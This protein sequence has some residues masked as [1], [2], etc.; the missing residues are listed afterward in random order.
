ME[1]FWNLRIWY[2]VYVNYMNNAG[3]RHFKI[4]K[5]YVTVCCD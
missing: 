2:E 5:H 3:E 1:K 4:I